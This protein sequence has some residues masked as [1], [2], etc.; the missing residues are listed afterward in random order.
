[1][2]CK[3]KEIRDIAERLEAEARRKQKA[4]FDIVCA[5]VKLQQEY[6]L[7]KNYSVS[8][9]I[10]GIL[11]DAGIN[12]IQGTAGYQYEQIPPTL[13]GRQVNDTWRQNE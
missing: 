13:K 2:L 6:R 8:D 3:L 10:R 4:H 7:A 9:S 1:M 12:I 11:N 5:L